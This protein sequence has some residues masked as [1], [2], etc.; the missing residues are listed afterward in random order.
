MRTSLCF[1]FL[2]L[3][4]MLWACSGKADL[5]AVKFWKYS[6][7]F[8]LGDLIDF[9]QKDIQEKNDTIYLK[10]VAIG[11]VAKIETRMND[12]V[13]HIKDPKNGTSGTYV[14]K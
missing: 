13:L 14:S 2:A 1:V 11:V 8:Y 6:D 12:Q 3:F 4:G 5:K 7:G 9:N 10:N